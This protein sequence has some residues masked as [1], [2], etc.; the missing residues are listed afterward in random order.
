LKYENIFEID[1]KIFL[2]KQIPND[3]RI[4]PDCRDLLVGLLKRNPNNRIN[5]KDFFRHP[6]IVND[7]TSQ[8]TRAVNISSSF[9]MIFSNESIG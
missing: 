2:L 8:I 6:F 3:A 1:S 5:F 9:F 4:S 7:L